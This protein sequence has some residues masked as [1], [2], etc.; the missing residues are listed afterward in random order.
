MCEVRA[1]TQGFLGNAVFA[2]SCV[3]T[4]SYHMCIWCN[5]FS[6]TIEENIIADDTMRVGVYA[7]W[8]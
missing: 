2:S 5:T 1:C 4:R 6:T 3:A 8:L 7:C